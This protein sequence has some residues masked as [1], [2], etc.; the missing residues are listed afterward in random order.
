MVWRRILNRSLM[1][2]VPIGGTVFTNKYY[3]ASQETG[4]YARSEPVPTKQSRNRERFDRF[5]TIQI[6]GQT[7]MI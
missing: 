1:V 5:A 6:D 2:S 7:F 3:Q 4:L